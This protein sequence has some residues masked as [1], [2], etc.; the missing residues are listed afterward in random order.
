VGSVILRDTPIH[1]L[2][3]FAIGLP[4]RTLKRGGC[5]FVAQS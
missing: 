1:T 5:R 4:V 3:A 2:T